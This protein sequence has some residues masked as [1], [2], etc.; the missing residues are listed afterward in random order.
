MQ[1]LKARPTRPPVHSSGQGQQRRSSGSSVRR[2]TPQ[3]KKGYDVFTVMAFAFFVRVVEPPGSKM[4]DIGAL[5]TKITDVDMRIRNLFEAP[6]KTKRPQLFP[7][8]S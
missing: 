8:H 6:Q 2:R 1:E 4:R 5:R 3:K 7:L